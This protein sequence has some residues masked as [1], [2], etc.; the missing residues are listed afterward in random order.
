MA[1]YAPCMQL[2]RITPG[3]REDTGRCHLLLMRSTGLGLDLTLVADHS[4]Q[5]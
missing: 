1:E 2:L 5:C 3:D 4:E